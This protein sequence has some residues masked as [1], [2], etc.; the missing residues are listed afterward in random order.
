MLE[1]VSILGPSYSGKSNLAESVTQELLHRNIPADIIKKDDAI[2]AH[3]REHYSEEDSTGGYSVLGA[4]RRGELPTSNAHEWMNDKIKRSRDL[5]HIAILEGG[6]RT[7][8]AQA[9]TLERI[10]FD[11]DN[12]RIFMLELP[13]KEVLAR[14]KERRKQS[15]RYDDGLLVASG[16]ILS[17]YVKS[18]SADAVRPNDSDV[19][20]LDATLSPDKLTEIVVKEI[21]DP[22][23]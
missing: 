14:A 20:L 23:R 6:T 7:R 9:E 10:D 18:N 15:G 11:D 1:I 22:Q 3:G 17:Q 16:K 5:G 12:F 13:F 8:K 19:T 4:I 2:K 21:L